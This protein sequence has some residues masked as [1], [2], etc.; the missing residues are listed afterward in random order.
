MTLSVGIG[1]IFFPTTVVAVSRAARHESGLASAVLNVSQ[2]LGGSIGLA[3]LGTI[4]ASV[5]RGQLTTGRPTPEAIDRALTAGFATAF[6]VGALISLAGFL[7]ALL[8]IR[9]RPQA[10]AAE[11]PRQAA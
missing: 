6:E 4:A 10:P 2:Q 1:L 5:T 8:I 3:V 11:A 7:L 9:V